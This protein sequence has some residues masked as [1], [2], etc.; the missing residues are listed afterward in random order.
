MRRV[1]LGS[2]KI[3]VDLAA[4]KL[5]ANA[6]DVALV[7]V[8]QIYPFPS[9]DLI[10]VLERYDRAEEIVW[11]QEEPENMGAWSSPAPC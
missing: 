10:P 5:R 6:K 1:I 2:G 4:S 8:E 7:R 11:A 3:M 9:S